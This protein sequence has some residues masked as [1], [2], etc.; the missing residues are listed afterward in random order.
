MTIEELKRERRWVLWRLETVNGKQTKVPYQPNGRKAAANNPATWKTYAECESVASQFSGIGL[1]LGDGVWG[2]DIDACCDSAFGRFTPES[3]EIVIGLDSYGEYS[4]SGTGCHVLGMGT[5][6]GPGLKKP[7][8]GCKAVEVKSDG[9]YFTFT[10]RHLSKTPPA[11]MDRQEQV[12]ALYERVCKISGKADV[13]LAVT[14]P[15]SEEE[16]FRRLMA[17]DMSDYHDDHSTADFALCILLAKKHGCNAFKIDTE[18]RASGL[19]RDK[20]ERDDY[21]ENTVTR[22]ITAVIKEAPVIFADPKD[23]P[24]EDDGET[25]FLVESLAGPGNDGWF[26][27]GELSVIG[28]PSGVG[29]TSWAMPLLEKIRHGQHVW[30]HNV[31]KPRDY[32]VL[33]HDRSKKAMRRTARALHMSEGAMQRIIRLCTEQ[34][35]R[36]P[37]EILQSCVEANPGVE[38]WFIEGLDLW[39]PDMNKMNVVAPIVDSLQRIATRYNV[40][41][42]ATVGAP[43]QKGKDRYFGRDGLFGSAA[44]ARKV[45]TVVLMGLH[46][47]EDPNSVRRCWVLPRAGRAEV[48][49][50][51]WSDEGLVLT[52]KPEDVQDDHSANARMLSAIHAAFGPNEPIEYRPSLGPERTF[53]RVKKWAIERRMLVV[54]NGKAYLPADGVRV[55]IN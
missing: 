37:A 26:P 53:Y 41:V 28:A 40:A 4:P 11:L 35:K 1:V 54:S 9:Y 15:L 21:R 18:F 55:N 32:R 45:E 30:N 23:E 8:P 7:H 2:V 46:N 36:E 44:L 42:L 10:G 6:P 31:S 19:Y 29:K 47:E 22:A 5:L 13:G 14:I 20:W 48:M 39:I 17:G 16:R 25:E 12:T 24:I 49:Y 38:I 34:Q 51:K 43:K 52:E 27:K 50:F 3:R 33:L